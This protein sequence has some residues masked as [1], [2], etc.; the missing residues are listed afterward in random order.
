LKILKN[1]LLL[2]LIYSSL[3]LSCELKLGLDNLTV[4]SEIWPPY[5]TQSQTGVLN[6]IATQQVKYVFESAN[7]PFEIKVMPW[8]RAFHLV[9]LN[10]NTLIYSISR[11]AQREHLFHWIHRLGHVKTSFVALAGRTDLIIKNEIDFK[12]Y[13]LILKRHEAA[14]QYFLD[15]GFDPKVNIIYVNNSEQALHLL[16]KGRGDIYP[17]TDSGFMPAVNKSGLSSGLFSLIYE[18]KEFELDLYLAANIQS[19]IK[20]INQ[21]KQAFS[22]Y[23]KS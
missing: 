4:Y 21:I 2:S 9:N 6:G 18:L 15:L 8:A 17:I 3:S 14:N 10:N 11:T 12:K 22:C 19:D 16:V 5:Q 1:V 7:F 13:T 23:A 20:L